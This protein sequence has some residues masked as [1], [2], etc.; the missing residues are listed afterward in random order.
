MLVSCLKPMALSP[1]ASTSESQECS[2][3]FGTPNTVLGNERVSDEARL[4]VA[5]IFSPRDRVHFTP[6]FRASAEGILKTGFCSK[7]HR[8]LPTANRFTADSRHLESNIG[9]C[10]SRRTAFRDR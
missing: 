3:R 9:E 6:V 2:A 8:M 7:S 5:S 10:S 1:R 4:L